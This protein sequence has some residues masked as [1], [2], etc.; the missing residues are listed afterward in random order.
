MGQV[1][2]ATDTKLN[3]QNAPT[4]LSAGEVMRTK[5]KALGTLLGTILLVP[6]LAFAQ[7]RV[8]NRFVGMYSGLALVMDVHHPENSNGYGIVH[9]S[10]SGWGRPL[11]YN[12]PLLSE[13]Q[14]EL[15]GKPLV[16]AGYTVF[17]LNHRATPRF[18]YPAPLA[19]VQRAV[20][21]IRFHK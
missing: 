6:T 3:R 7:A 16:T 1:S 2:Q 14:V 12:A 11:A 18:R 13:G 15:Y 19:D 5:G 9:I 17:S 10:G 20:R 21:F 8:E 4:E